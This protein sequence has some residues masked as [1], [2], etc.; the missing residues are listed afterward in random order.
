MKENESGVAMT[1]N[2]KV[3]NNASRRGTQTRKTSNGRRRRTW[4][5]DLREW[6]GSKTLDWD[7]T[8]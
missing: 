4:V 6:T 5:D 3:S 1:A 7:Y 8:T 2:V